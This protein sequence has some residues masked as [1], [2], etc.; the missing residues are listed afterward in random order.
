MTNEIIYARIGKDIFIAG[1]SLET[2]TT[3]A[4]RIWPK[5][6]VVPMEKSKIPKEYNWSIIRVEKFPN[7]HEIGTYLLIENFETYGGFKRYFS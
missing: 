2:I 1:L 4:E 3:T 6:R 5:A 7:W